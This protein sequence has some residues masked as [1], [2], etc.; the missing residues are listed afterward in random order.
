MGEGVRLA[1]TIIIIDAILLGL[2]LAA[3]VGLAVYFFALPEGVSAI[4]GTF[5]GWIAKSFSE[6]HKML[7]DRDDKR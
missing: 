6:L 5:I 2:S 7:S 3:M 4:L 1:R